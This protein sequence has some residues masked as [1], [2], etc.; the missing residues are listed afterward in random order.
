MCSIS[1]A[2]FVPALAFYAGRF[3]REISLGI[4]TEAARQQIL[5]VLTRPLRLKVGQRYAVECYD[6]CE[7]CER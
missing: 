2:L 6:Y 4:P 1:R 7:C 5:K 3:D